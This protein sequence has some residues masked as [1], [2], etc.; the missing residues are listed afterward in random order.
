MQ[1]NKM[2]LS[3]V[4]LLFPLTY[5]GACLLIS[6]I[7]VYVL[8][9][10]DPKF[11][12]APSIAF[13]L[14]VALGVYFAFLAS[15]SYFVTLIVQRKEIECIPLSRLVVIAMLSA[16][17]SWGSI[18]APVKNESLFHLLVVLGPVLFT[19]VLIR[20]GRAWLLRNRP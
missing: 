20:I 9:H 11:S 17:L 5:F 19:T 13:E 3:I 8:G 4:L 6:Y 10:F 14:E 12:G 1:R 7:R 15:V 16:L 18:W 2:V